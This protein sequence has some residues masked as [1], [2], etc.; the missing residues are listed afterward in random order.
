MK[1]N[2]ADQDDKVASMTAEFK[3]YAYSVSHDLSAPIRA[4][5]GFSNILAE[6]HAGSLNDE[7]KEYL[8]LIVQSGQKLQAMMEGL[9]AY[10]RLNT[11][12]KSPSRVD[13]NLVLDQCRTVFDEEIKSKGA[14]LEISNLPAVRADADQ[15]FQ[16]FTVL[17]DN[18]LKFQPRGNKPHISIAAERAGSF[19][20]FTVADNGIGVKPPHYAKIF[21]LFQ[22][23]HTDE[24][25]PGVGVGLTLAEKIVH[26]HGGIISCTSSGMQGLKIL[27]TL[28]VYWNEGAS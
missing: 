25:F 16:L 1:A 15:A 23:L 8:A 6:E 11:Q 10:S 19:W 18:A 17:L 27:F 22:R 4:M 9:L 14:T 13:C 28:P 24:E 5:V 12:F 7:G 21:K 2:I 3:D 26:R 20:Q